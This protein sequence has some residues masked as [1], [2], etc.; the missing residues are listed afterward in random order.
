VL[1]VVPLVSFLTTKH[2]KAPG[3]M[4]AFVARFDSLFLFTGCTVN[5]NTRNNRLLLRNN[6]IE[7]TVSPFASLAR[8]R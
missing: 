3:P 7:G 8:L 6:E 4:I 1:F 5:P 2:P